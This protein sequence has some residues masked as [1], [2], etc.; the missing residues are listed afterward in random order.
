MSPIERYNAARDREAYA[1]SLSPEGRAEREA[2]NA[3]LAHSPPRER[4]AR[5][6]HAYAWPC[7]M[8][9]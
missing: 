3:A 8:G 4:D 9:A 2:A 7:D 6:F 5:P 1:Y